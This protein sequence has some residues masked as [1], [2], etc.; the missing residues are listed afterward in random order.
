MSGI[1]DYSLFYKFIKTFSPVGFQGIDRDDPLVQELEGMMKETNQFFFVGDLIQVKI[2]FTSKRSEEMIG[3]NP[4]EVTPYHFFEATHPDDIHRHNLRRSK[5][6]GLGQGLYIAERGEALISTEFRF[7]NP[8]GEYPNTLVQC[9][10]FYTEIPLKTVYLIQLL[11]DISRFKKIKHGYHYYVGDDISLFR[12]P[13]DELL[14]IGSVFS[15]REFEIIRYIK[16]GLTSEQISEKLFLSVHTVN[17]HR[18]NILEKT[19]KSAL[20]DVIYELIERGFL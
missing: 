19:G 16:S 9:Y 10:M 17:T 18:N 6:F 11:T 2:H 14:H 5:L 12:F 1:Q 15:D 7:R 4:E 3:V 8:L 20:S 13:D